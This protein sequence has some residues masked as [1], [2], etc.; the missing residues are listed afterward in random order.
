MDFEQALNYRQAIRSYSDRSITVEDLKNIV[1]QAQKSPS[2]VDSQPWK[3]Y[4]ATGDAVRRLASQQADLE[5]AGIASR[6]EVPVRHRRDWAQI[7][8]EN[9]AQNSTSKAAF[10]KQ[11]QA[12]FEESQKYLYHAPAVAYLT[13]PKDS[14]DWSKFDLGLFASSLMLAAAAK[15]I[16]SIPSYSLVKYPELARKELAIPTNETIFV[17]I[18]LGYRSDSVLNQYRSKRM[19]LDDVLTIRD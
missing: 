4:I 16:D 5:D 8:R 10:G 19:A 7:P 6:P 18:A 17:G 15:Q 14:P 9:M 13:I 1:A 3:V 2:W 12:S 11:H